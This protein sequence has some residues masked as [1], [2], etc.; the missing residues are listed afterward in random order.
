MF[1]GLAALFSSGILLNPVALLALVLG[2]IEGINFDSSQLVAFF[3]DWPIYALAVFVALVYNF[4][5]VRCYLDENEISL[6][7]S[8]MMAN[9]V[10]SA[11]LFL[12]VNFFSVLFI[13]FLI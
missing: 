1:R 8:K 12:A 7:Y 3:S 9:S 10:G 11:F 5:F 2:I 4:V 6:D 13:Y